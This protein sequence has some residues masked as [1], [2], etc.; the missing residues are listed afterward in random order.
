MGYD[1]RDREIQAL[2]DRLSRMSRA[3]LRINESL[4]F[5]S[6]LQEVVDSARAL[7][8]SRY[9]ALTIH[10]G[11]G[12]LPYFIVSGITP[13]EQQGLWD[14]PQGRQFFDYLS[15]LETPLR[16]ADVSEYFQALETPEFL[17][18]VPVTSL[19]VTPIRHAGA[20]VGTIYL[21]RGEEGGEFTPEDE[22]IVVMFASQAALVI[23]NAR[24]HREEQRARTDMETLVDTSPVAVLV[25]DAGTAE[26]VSHNREATRIAGDVVPEART[27]QEVLGVVRVRRADG[28]EV[29]VTEI[30]LQQVMSAGEL[31]R[32]EEIVIEGPDD[33]RV[34]VL[35]NATPIRGEDGSVETYVIT[36]Q[37]MT[38]LEEMERLRAEFLAMVSHELRTPLTSV[39]GSVANLLDPAAALDP[40]EVVQFHRI[41]DAQAD[42][43][44]DLI[45]DLLDVARI[46]TGSLSVS[47]VPEDL[48]GLVDEAKAI[49]LSGGSRNNIRIEIPP[50]LPAV[51]ADRRRI[52][53][54]IGNLFSNAARH[55]PES[56]VIRVSAEL[57]GLYVRVS[58]IDAGRGIPADH[59][60]HLFR[61]FSQIESG[62]ERGDTGLGLAIC[63]GI[64][65]AHGGRIRAE[66]DGPGLGARF[67]FTLPANGGTAPAVADDTSRYTAGSRRAAS[68]MPRILAVDDDPQTLRYVRDVLSKA[69]YSVAV[70]AD[71]EEVPRLIE[72]NP[73]DLVLLDL[74]LPGT[75]GIEVM[76]TIREMVNVPAIFLSAYGQD[77]VIARAF[78][79]GA[80]DYVVKPFSPTELAARIQAA[81]RR[82]DS[83]QIDHLGAPYVRADLVV[84]YARSSVTVGGASVELT[85]LEYRLLAELSANAGRLLTHEQLLQRVWGQ[86]NSGSSGPVRTYVKRLRR[87]LGD[88]PDSPTY[89]FTRRGVGYW[90]EEG[91]GGGE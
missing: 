44:R 16:V 4:D 72:D 58:V 24:R 51:L 1:D 25:F 62:E 35:L 17:P 20:R 23:V 22:D 89:I 86:D 77:Q 2:K 40:A 47:P 56:S 31:V 66:S 6:V 28:T 83:P 70:T 11:E 78:Q 85:P 65:E 37:D 88:D 59:L 42:R 81:L 12:E 9:A 63:K 21:S 91:E 33:R 84:E 90:M 76:E 39:K 67:T 55:S 74:M 41:I 46:Q 8:G 43:M 3:S 45:S 61:K 7:T 64:V 29:P 18:S 80:V 52:V 60:P 15:R 82:Q 26:L 71:P 69:G 50:G 48:P 68:E 32:V 53:Q 38:P 5:D 36:L 57:E 34:T 27:L 87:K 49:Y 79:R 10:G 73:P 54:V 13:E 14:M 30:P 19:L 75:D